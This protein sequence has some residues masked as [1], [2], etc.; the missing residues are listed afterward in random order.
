MCTNANKSEL[1]KSRKCGEYWQGP[2]IDRTSFQND[3]TDA[4]RFDGIE[5]NKKKAYIWICDATKEQNLICQKSDS[6]EMIMNNLLEGQWSVKHQ[7]PRNCPS[8]W[9]WMIAKA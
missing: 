1:A 5:H 4:S 8:C 2:L 6:T 3:E 9:Q 7:T